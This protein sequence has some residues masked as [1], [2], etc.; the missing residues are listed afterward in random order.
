MG[1]R[2]DMDMSSLHE[3]KEKLEAYL[4]ELKS[5]AVAFSSGVDSTF[6][7]KA[8]CDT[9]GEAAIAVTAVSSV[10]PESEA[11]EAR[12]FCL[13]NGIEQLIVEMDPL[14]IEGFKENPRDR[15]YI[16]K[17]AIFSKLKLAAAAKGSYCLAEGS[18]MD[19]MGDYRPGMKAVEELGVKSP[20]RH[21]GLTKEEIRA[22]SREMGLPT[23]DKPSF[24]CLASRFPYGEK[25]DREKLGMVEEAEK[26][27]LGQ[28][29]RQARVRIHGGGN[30]A[31][32]ELLPSEI[33]KLLSEEFRTEV[34]KT[35]KGLGFSYVAL[36]LAGYRSG[37][38]N[39]VL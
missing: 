34:N 35:L 21:A 15:C 19:D 33:N 38:M 28:G 5:V 37:S 23:Y 14:S 36:D 26:F 18:N 27:L 32:I 24:A 13:N 9:L 4:K 10:F 16:C 6:L 20:L 22:L 29:F 11:R 1:R 2:Q 12:E 7:L 25:I 3:K 39:E 17:K 31:R 30:I 8:A